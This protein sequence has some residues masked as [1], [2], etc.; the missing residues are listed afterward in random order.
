[1]ER[2]FMSKFFGEFA[3]SGPGSWIIN[4]VAVVAF[5]IVAKVL[6]S[7]LPDSGPLGA[8]KAGVNFV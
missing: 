8:V 7:R 4:G 2:G 5:I 6:V 1:M 3:D